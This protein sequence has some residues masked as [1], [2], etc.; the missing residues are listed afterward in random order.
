MTY[1]QKNS[2]DGLHNW[3]VVKRLEQMWLESSYLAM[4]EENLNAWIR[5][6]KETGDFKDPEILETP[7]ESN[8]RNNKE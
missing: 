6:R 4:W 1:K 2:R 5:W 3:H 7:Y 8:R